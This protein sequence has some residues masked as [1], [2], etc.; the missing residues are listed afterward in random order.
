LSVHGTEE[1]DVAPPVHQHR[2]KGDETDPALDADV[3]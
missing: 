2:T 3:N 1:A